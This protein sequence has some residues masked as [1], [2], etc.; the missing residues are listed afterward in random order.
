MNKLSGE[1]PESFIQGCMPKDRDPNN[2]N[3]MGPGQQWGA[4]EPPQPPPCERAFPQSTYDAIRE[5]NRPRPNS[6]S[7]TRVVGRGP[8]ILNPPAAPKASKDGKK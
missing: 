1:M 2:R 4:K 8:I 6:L 7:G 3:D 5:D